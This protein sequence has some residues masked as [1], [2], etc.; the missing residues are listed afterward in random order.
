MIDEVLTNLNGRVRDIQA[1][2]KKDDDQNYLLTLTLPDG[3]KEKAS[4][5]S[6]AHGNATTLQEKIKNHLAMLEGGSY[7]QLSSGAFVENQ[8]S[9]QIEEVAG[10]LHIDGKQAVL[11]REDGTYFSIPGEL[12]H[13]YTHFT[14]TAEDSLIILSDHHDLER[15]DGME[16]FIFNKDKTVSLEEG[17]GIPLFRKRSD[18]SA[19][20]A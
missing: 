5:F 14:A 12:I 18:A 20:T 13:S 1:D 6:L 2:P 19:T 15:T 7:V 11:A 16:G 4:L 10:I 8:T 9:A 17:E 3:T